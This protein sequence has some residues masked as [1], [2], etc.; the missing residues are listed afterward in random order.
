MDDQRARIDAGNEKVFE[1]EDH[2]VWE[3]SYRN[4]DSDDDDQEN[5]FRHA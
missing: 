5:L 4:V 1:L 3:Y 2:A